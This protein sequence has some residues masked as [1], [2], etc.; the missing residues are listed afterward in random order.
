MYGFSYIHIQCHKNWS[1]N[2]RSF[3]SLTAEVWPAILEGK[4]GRCCIRPDINDLGWRL[5]IINNVS[6]NTILNPCDYEDE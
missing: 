6:E 2:S 3:K 4:A 5:R 1:Y